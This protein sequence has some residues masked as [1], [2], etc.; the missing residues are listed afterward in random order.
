MPR[1]SRRWRLLM[2]AAGALLLNAACG[3]GDGDDDFERAD[4]D[5]AV[6]VTLADF[7]FRGLPASVKGEKVF[8]TATN[9]GPSEHELEVLDPGGEAVDEIEAHPAGSGTKT[10]AVRLKPGTYT[11]QCILTTPEGKSHADL[12]MTAKLQVQ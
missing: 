10:L 7:A 4:A 5:T 8:F 9:A 6:D 1:R 11:V 3:G 2:V 12:G